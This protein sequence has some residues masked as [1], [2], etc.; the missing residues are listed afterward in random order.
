MRFRCSPLNEKKGALKFNIEFKRAFSKLLGRSER[1]GVNHCR[2]TAD[3]FQNTS[4]RFY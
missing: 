2:L 3:L 1:T 4:C